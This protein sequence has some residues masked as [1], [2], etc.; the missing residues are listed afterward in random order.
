MRGM[1]LPL[2]QSARRGGYRSPHKA[3]MDIESIL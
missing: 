1:T 2:T 3:Q